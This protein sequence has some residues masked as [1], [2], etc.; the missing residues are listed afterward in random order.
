MQYNEPNE[1]AVP[2][3]TME[4]LESRDDDQQ[5]SN[6]SSRQQ[7]PQRAVKRPEYLQDYYLATVQDY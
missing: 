6:S 1:L 5:G 2:G 3:D 4:L 7:R